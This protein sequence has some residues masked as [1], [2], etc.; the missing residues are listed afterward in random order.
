M[1]ALDNLPKEKYDNL[2]EKLNSIRDLP[3]K[4]HLQDYK[5]VQNWSLDFSPHPLYPSIRWVSHIVHFSLNFIHCEKWKNKVK[6]LQ[7]R[8]FILT[9]SW[10]SQFFKVRP[11]IF[12]TH[13]NEVDLEWPHEIFRSENHWFLRPPLHLK[14]KRIYIR[15]IVS[16]VW[17]KYSTN[18]LMI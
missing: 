1:I 4:Y 12:N 8:N 6:N 7:F 15:I 5:S 10:L 14:S 3:D 17:S 11:L 9:L 13:R 18:F 2:I 16:I